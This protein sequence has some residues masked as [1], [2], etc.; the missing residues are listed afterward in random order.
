MRELRTVPVSQIV[1][2]RFNG[3]RTRPLK[4]VETL[5]ERIKRNGFEAT[6]APWVTNGGATYE[7]FA[8]ATRIEA[9][10]LAGV[11]DV[12]V[13]VFTDVSEDEIA[14]L[15]DEDNEND[16]YHRPVPIV[17]VWAEYHRLA[18]AEGWTQD[19]IA[20][21]K[22]CDVPTVSL[23]IKAHEC[24][25]AIKAAAL[26]GMF[27]EGH[28]VAVLGVSL[29]VQT[30]SS[31]LTTTSAQAELVDEVLS[32]H[33]GSTAGI[34]PTVA[35]VRDAAKRW[36]SFI[37]DAGAKL[38]ALPAGARE[39]FVGRLSA[40]KARSESAVASAYSFALDEHM[41]NAAKAERE[42]RAAQSAAEK[43]RVDA[44]QQALAAEAVATRIAKVCLGDARDCINDA[45]GGIKLLLTDPPYGV[46]F[47][48]GRRTTSAKKS[49]IANDGTEDALALLADVLAASVAKMA[50]DSHA[51]IFTGWRH[52]P[53]FRAL[54]ESAGLTIKGSLVWVKNNH[55]TGDLNGSFAP[56]HERIIHAVKGKPSLVSRI[57][58][59]VFGKDKQ[60]SDHPTEKPRDLLRQLIEA[61]TSAGELVADP[62]AGSGSTLLEARALE[63][64]F[65]GCEIDEEYH[66]GIAD[67]LGR[68]R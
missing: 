25:P 36:K 9:A 3:R 22:G 26:D 21:A 8:G 62:F 57:D 19:R 12:P 41:A 29:D 10:R 24:A 14:R 49:K 66:R 52:E 28:V 33:R 38:D 5:A 13:F 37:A 2:S 40:T 48:S 61:T 55:G 31:W 27:D 59:V 20:R 42:A 45:P 50:D 51:L 34:K 39:S 35:K 46:D 17:D 58:D 6:R 65:W 53:A 11:T 16:E 43:A 7:V 1:M 44:E 64:D 56:R 4:D 30:L 18:R 60:N 67:A 68:D 32:K 15:A 23:R 54:I 63:R 47:Q